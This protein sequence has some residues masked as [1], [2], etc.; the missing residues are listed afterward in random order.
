MPRS[1]MLLQDGPARNVRDG[2]QVQHR[3]PAKPIPTDPRM[4]WFDV[5]WRPIVTQTGL[6][7]RPTVWIDKAGGVGDM[8]ECVKAPWS[9]GDRLYVRECFHRD[10]DHDRTFYRADADEYGCVPY[11]MDGAGGF[12]G[13]VG[14]ANLKG[15]WKPNIHMPRKYARTWVRVGR[16]WIERVKEISAAG[17]IAEGCPDLP[18]DVSLYMWFRD[19]WTGI[20]G[21]ESWESGWAVCCEFERCEAP[22]GE[23]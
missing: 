6:Q 3:E 17:I 23:T 4:D 10:D 12:G 11:L 18:G 13:G 9:P 21:D 8:G 14:E 19:L 20:Y 16:V 1:Y 2:V 7:F 15:C 22:E 5:E